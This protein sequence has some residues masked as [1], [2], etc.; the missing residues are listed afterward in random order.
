MVVFFSPQNAR[1]GTQTPIC[2]LDSLFF[3]PK[4]HQAIR[5]FFRV[6]S[7]SVSLQVSL[8]SSPGLLT[9]PPRRDVTPC[10]G[11]G[12][13][14]GP[15]AGERS[16]RRAAPSPPPPPAPD[17]PPP[18]AAP[19]PARRPRPLPTAP[20]KGGAGR[21][22]GAGPQPAPPR[23]RPAWPATETWRSSR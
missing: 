12:W 5:A 20:P 22:R 13:G 11:R 7:S 2:P 21:G 15:G 4:R 10:R 23:R 6:S 1:F 16:P 8:T 18:T 17:P 9:S 19:A 3:P 14:R